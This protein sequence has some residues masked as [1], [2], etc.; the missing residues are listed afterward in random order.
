ME[1][2]CKPHVLHEQPREEP[3]LALLVITQQIYC[4]DIRPL[5]Q[6]PFHRSRP[7]VMGS[8]LSTICSEHF[9][10]SSS[11]KWGHRGLVLGVYM[12][13]LIIQYSNPAWGHSVH[14]RLI[15][16]KQLVL[17]RNGSNMYMYLEYVWYLDTFSVQGQPE[18]SRF[19]FDF[20]LL[21]RNCW[22]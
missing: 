10:C 4:H 8:Y 16:W 15:S 9:S 13:P 11:S 3:C 19:I 1:C 18:V 5:T 2:I 17:N 22:L 6:K 20:R 7:T 21:S 14:F 12:V